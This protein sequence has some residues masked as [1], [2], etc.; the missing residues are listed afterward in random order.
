MYYNKNIL[1]IK[2]IRNSK[3]QNIIKKYLTFSTKFFLYI[4]IFQSQ[5]FNKMEFWCY[6]I[7]YGLRINSLIFKKHMP[8]FS[9]L[10]NNIASRRL[11][12]EEKWTISPLKCIKFDKWVFYDNFSKK[13]CQIF[14]VKI[15][16]QKLMC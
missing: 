3:I 10:L 13:I 16:I 7:W 11:V 4:Y 8:L 9:L 2:R 14:F 5:I 15:V 12:F 6:L 1:S